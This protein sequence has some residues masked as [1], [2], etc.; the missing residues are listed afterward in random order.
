MT[1]AGASDNIWPM[2]RDPDDFDSIYRRSANYFGDQPDR[3]LVDHIG[4]IDRRRPALDVGAGQGRNAM[5]LAEHGTRVDAIDPSAEAVAATFLA[6][7]P[8]PCPAG[9]RR[10]AAHKWDIAPAL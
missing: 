8:Q 3:I 10:R 2:A 9:R 6:M 5:F 1:R 7:G 4:L